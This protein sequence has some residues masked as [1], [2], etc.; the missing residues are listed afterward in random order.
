MDQ[1]GGGTEPATAESQPRTAQSGFGGL[2]QQMLNVALASPIW[3]YVLVP[4]ARASIV[5]TAEENG[6]PWVA[7]KEWLKSQKDA[8]WNDPGHDN[9]DDVSYPTYY[10]KSFHAYSEGNLSYDAA[11]EQELAS[12]A[13]GARNFPQYSNRG[14]DVFRGAFERALSRI[15]AR[16]RR[17]DGENEVTIVDFGCGTGTSTRRLAKRYP[18]EAAKI[19]GIDLSPYFIDVGRTL[20]KLAPEAIGGGRS[21]GWIAD[22]DADP[23]IQLRRGDIADTRLPSNSASVVNLGL[24]LHEL[25]TSV[26]KRVVREAHRIL[27]PG[28]QLWV[29]EMDFESPAYRAQRENALLFSLLRATEPYLD[30]Y[31]DGMPALRNYIVETFDKVKIAAATGRHYALVAEK[32][33]EDRT[34]GDGEKVRGLEDYRFDKNMKYAVEDTHLKPWESKQ[35]L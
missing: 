30:E 27:E 6:I 16:L 18:D 20:L 19:I 2:A 17:I 3:K 25:P 23:R 13:I 21:E 9:H 29:S 4:Q 26:A 24:V 34:N 22:V 8:P 10:R 33:L 28:G 11:F 32:G 31:A 1:C 5:K 35:D 12:R 14:E 15:G 7:A